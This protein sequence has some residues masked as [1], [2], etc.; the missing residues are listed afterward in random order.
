MDLLDHLTTIGFT[1]YE[2]K[3]YLALLRD[4]PT[5]GYQIGKAAGVP[6]SM[7]YEALGRLH[8]RGAVLKSDEAKGAL[9]RPVPPDVLIDRYE[10]EQ[11]RITTR[12]REGLRAL[13]AA[14]DEEHFWSMAGHAPVLSYAAEMIEGAQREI[15]LVIDDQLAICGPSSGPPASAAL[16]SARC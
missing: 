13:Y 5:T 6:R 10:Q 2:A 8:V 15:M 14:S 9:Y 3:V 16:R 1:E 4:N 11:R 7:V 12:L